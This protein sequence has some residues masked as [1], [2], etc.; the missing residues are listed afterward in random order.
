M[1]DGSA[2]TLTPL[3]GFLAKNERL[4]HFLQPISILAWNTNSGPHELCPVNSLRKYI[5]ATSNITDDFV[6]TWPDS[7][8]RCSCANLTTILKRIIDVADPGKLPVGR[9]TRK[10]AASLTFIRDHSLQRT[11]EVGQ[12]ALTQPFAHRYLSPNV[13][14]VQCVAMGSAPNRNDDHD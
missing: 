14:N 4:D 8:R 10:V 6:F 3:P 7:G 2:V 5:T 13:S 9:D 1:E 11:H 12:W